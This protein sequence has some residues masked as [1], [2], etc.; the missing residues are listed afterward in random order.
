MS[1]TSR[2]LHFLLKVLR[3]RRFIERS[4][5]D[6][7]RTGG[8][9]VPS[10]FGQD[11]AAKDWYVGECRLV[12]ASSRDKVEQPLNHVYFLHGGAYVM[13]GSALHRRFMETLARNFGLRLTYIEYPLGPE[14]DV[15]TCHDL[16][17]QAYARILED[18]PRD[19]VR[20][21]GDSAGGGMALALLHYLRD[22]DLSRMPN[23]TVLISP[24]VDASMS[25]AD[26]LHYATKDLVL[27]INGLFKAA[28]SFA[29]GE[30]LRGPLL[31][32]LFQDQSGLGDILML[33]STH[34]LFFP[35]CKD[36]NEKMQAA[37]GTEVRF[38]VSEGVTHDWVLLP[39]PEARASTRIIGEY[40]QS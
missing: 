29:H 16:V 9:V 34:E 17:R 6:P 18:Y 36:L 26:A 22:G 14:S 8:I 2:L 23:R 27:T 40:L 28:Q 10:R 39:T 33:V 20:L 31:A 15:R 4:F 25:H 30:S 32:P 1:M 12:T 38:V 35:D 7:L 3:A 11:I 19:N 13:E 24:W 21:M 5:A 37:E